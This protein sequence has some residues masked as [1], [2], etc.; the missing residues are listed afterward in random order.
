[1]K[2]IR[3]KRLNARV[4]L[5][6]CPTKSKDGASSRLYGIRLEEHNGDWVRTWAFKLDEDKAKREGFI[7]E[8]TS[9]TI[10]PADDYPGCPYCGTS[11]IA[12]C[13]CGR[14]FCFQKENKSTEH[15]TATCPWCNQAG[16]YHTVKT[17]HV[18]GGDL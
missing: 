18:Q 3:A 14:L 15:I 2:E 12:Q 1:M 11:A 6:R 4:V 13:S 17:L 7:T 8:R 5:C 9:G 16:D 10:S